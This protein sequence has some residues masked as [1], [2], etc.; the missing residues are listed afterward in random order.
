MYY[1]EIMFGKHLR[2]VKNFDSA[3]IRTHE[4][5]RDKETSEVVQ[6]IKQCTHTL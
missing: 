3:A 4:R 6:Y 5:E 1:F 2:H